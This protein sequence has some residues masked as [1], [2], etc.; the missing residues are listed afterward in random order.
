MT[1]WA[2]TQTQRF[3][4]AVRGAGIANCKATSRNDID[5][6]LIPYFGPR[7]MT[8]LPLCGSPITFIKNGKTPTLSVGDRDGNAR[9]LNPMSSGTP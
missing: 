1:M 9:Y 4:A 7:S 2:V 8:I 5:Q 3:H 6:W